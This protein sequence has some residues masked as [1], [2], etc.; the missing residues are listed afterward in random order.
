MLHTKR[1][2]YAFPHCMLL[3]FRSSQLTTKIRSIHQKFT[4]NLDSIKTSLLIKTDFR[5]QFQLQILQFSN[6]RING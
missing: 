6:F 1:Q 5:L 4:I 3:P 2:R